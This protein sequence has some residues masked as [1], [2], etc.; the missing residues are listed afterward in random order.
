MFCLINQ[1]WRKREFRMSYSLFTL[2]S[3]IE[4][5]FSKEIESYKS[6]HLLGG[7]NKNPTVGQYK[8]ISHVGSL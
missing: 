4:K 2:R 5:L 1:L 6:A 8:G 3:N 7:W